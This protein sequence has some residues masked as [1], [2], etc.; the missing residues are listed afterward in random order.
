M[1]FTLAA[2]ITYAERG[3]STT[4]LDFDEFAPRLLVLLHRPQRLPRGGREVPRR[5][6]PVGTHREG[7]LRRA[8]ARV[9]A[10][11]LPLPD[12][13]LLAD[14]SAAA[15]QHRPRTALQALAAV[16]GGAQ[17]LHV[18]GMD[19]ALA[20]PSELA[21]KVALR[22]QQILLEES[23]VANTI[24]PLGGSYCDRGPDRPDRAPRQRVP[25]ADRRARRDG[26]LHRVRL[27]PA[28]DRRRRL[29]L[30]A[31]QGVGRA[32]DRRRQRLPRRRGRAD[33]VRAPQG[34]SAGRGAQ[35]RRAPRVPGAGATRPASRSGSSAA[36]AAAGDENLMPATIEAVRAR[37]TGGEIVEAVRAVFGSY[38]ETAVF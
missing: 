18:S 19:E 24:D 22:T 34:R 3:R 35:D 31:R 37:A 5:P 15:E 38:V 13:G 17:S 23:G 4:G 20:I 9:D 2:A 6:S 27:V 12:G 29:Q 11:A 14:G 28:G 30:P 32:A 16:A 8:E 36:R 7:A 25:G 1:A 10:A 33:A 26:R 21:M